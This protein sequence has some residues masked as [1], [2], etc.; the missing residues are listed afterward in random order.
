M[1]R[2]P[3]HA[4]RV[5]AR[6]PARQPLLPEL[7]RDCP[8]AAGGAAAARFA[9]LNWRG[10]AFRVWAG[11]CRDF[12]P[13]M[14]DREAR[15]QAAIGAALARAGVHAEAS[16]DPAET[17]GALPIPEDIPKV[18][19]TSSEDASP[20]LLSL[21]SVLFDPAPHLMSGQTISVVGSITVL[22][23]E[24][25]RIDLSKDG[26]KMIVRIDEVDRSCFQDLG[27]AIG[28]TVVAVGRVK[29]H[30][31]RTFFDAHALRRPGAVV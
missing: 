17:S 6:R 5:R 14:A 2:L 29:K 28:S 24:L 21:Q 19:A 31:R 12:F 16:I 7:L 4:R 3:P 20:P 18:G 1:S 22:D 13:C 30:Q 8:R 15:R 10:G 23:L 11:L 26:A 27:I 25:G 9:R